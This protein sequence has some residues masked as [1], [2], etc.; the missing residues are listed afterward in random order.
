MR[1]IRP[2]NVGLLSLPAT[3]YFLLLFA[4]PL[5][6]LLAESLHDRSGWTL[7]HYARFFATAYNWSVIGRTLR[8]AVLC[9]LFCTILGYPAAF[10]LARTRG[11]LQS[12]LIAALLLPLS[13]SVIVKAFG[14]TVLL[15]G[16][17]V[18]NQALQAVGLTDAPL[19]LL[20]TEAGLLIGITNIFLP[21]MVL[22]LFSVVRQLDPRLT[23]A[24]ATLGSTPL[25]A[26]LTV[27]LR[28]TLPGLIAGITLVFSLSIAAYVIPTLLIGDTYQTLPTMIATSFLY[29]QDP[30]KGSVAGVTLLVLSVATII[31]S[32]ALSR[33]FTGRG[34]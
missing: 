1:R 14:W 15:R 12:A 23:D 7:A 32:A 18:I 26:F 19:R 22:P 27:T 16:N 2:A 4:L 8:V 17:G 6:V 30:G 28:L 11:L 5:G 31:T 10:A 20:F 34:R 24:A 29:L 25:H 3:L 13:V 9:T 33:R 21:F